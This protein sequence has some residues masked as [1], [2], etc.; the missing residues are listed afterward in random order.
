MVQSGRKDVS[1]MNQL[2]ERLAGMELVRVEGNVQT[3]KRRDQVCVLC[4]C[5]CVC[6]C[7]VC[8]CAHLKIVAEVCSIPNTYE[9]PTH[10]YFRNV[11][12]LRKKFMAA[13]LSYFL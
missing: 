6:V 11:H 12:G 7:T 10:M 3:N 2:L 13:T 8:V 1:L 9:G 4:V 5:V